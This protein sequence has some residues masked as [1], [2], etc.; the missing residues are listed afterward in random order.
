M[1]IRP[2]LEE[3]KYVFR[4]SD[5]NLID[6]DANYNRIGLTKEARRCASSSENGDLSG[7]YYG[8]SEFLLNPFSSVQSLSRVRLFATP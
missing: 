3:D 6:L 8:S 1:C 4:Q 5:V 7:G 2:G